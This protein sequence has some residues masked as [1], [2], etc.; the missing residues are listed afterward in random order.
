MTKKLKFSGR[1]KNS[2]T[3]I[4]GTGVNEIDGELM[5]LDGTQVLGPIDRSSL[6]ITGIGNYKD[7]EN[8]VTTQEKLSGLQ[9]TIVAAAITFC[10]ENKLTDIDRIDFH[11]DGFQDSVKYGRWAPSTDSSITTYGYEGDEYK[12]IGEWM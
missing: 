8:P 9:E 5:L 2:G 12:K 11:V 7:F 10:L 4:E 3:R 6:R 1:S